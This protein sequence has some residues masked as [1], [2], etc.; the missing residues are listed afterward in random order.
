MNE[1]DTIAIVDMTLEFSIQIPRKD[2]GALDTIAE[3]LMMYGVHGSTRNIS[4]TGFNYNYTYK[5][6][7]RGLTLRKKKSSVADIK[8]DQA[9]GEINL[10]LQSDDA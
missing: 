5:K 4:G 2:L 10:L 3:A 6:S 1:N 8:N 7:R 9:D